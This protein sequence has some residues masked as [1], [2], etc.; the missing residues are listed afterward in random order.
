MRNLGCGGNPEKGGEQ[1]T[2]GGVEGRRHPQKG[3]NSGQLPLS[4]S[5]ERPLPARSRPPT[6]C[7]TDARSPSLSRPASIP[8]PRSASGLHRRPR[9]D[10][11]AKLGV[12]VCTVALVPTFVHARIDTSVQGSFRGACRTPAST[13][14][15][16]TAYKSIAEP[17]EAGS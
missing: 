9:P 1:Q 15:T 10:R 6:F 13:V 16:G 4:Q 8:A 2:G 5:H 14:T 11:H 17:D 7:G 3:G 12:Q